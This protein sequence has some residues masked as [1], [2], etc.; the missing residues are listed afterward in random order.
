MKHPALFNKERQQKILDLMHRDGSLNVNSL[1]EHFHVTPA[2]IRADLN[3]LE[4]EGAL[5]RTHGGAIPNISNRH[6][7]KMNERHN[8]EKKNRIAEKA[9]ELVEEGNILLLDTGTTMVCFA[10][11]LVNSPIKELTVFSN[12]IDVIRILEEKESFSLHLLA[13]KMRNGYHYCYGSQI[14]WILQDCHFNK[15]FLSS[16]AISIAHG[17]TTANPELAQIKREMIDASDEIVLL[18]DSSKLHHVDFQKFAD[19]K[20]INV[21]IMDSELT[22]EDRYLL[23]SSV[24]KMILA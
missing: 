22:E 21:L 16:S 6:E 8:E 2:T 20:Q 5:V 23:E 15:L 19:L 10:K 12:D 11:A 14:S 9:T 18:V 17:L 7:P 13:G 4:A 24:K 3:H 1:A